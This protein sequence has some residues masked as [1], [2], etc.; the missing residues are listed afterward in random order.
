MGKTAFLFSGQGSQYVGMGMELYNSYDIVRDTLDSIDSILGYNLLDIIFNGPEEVLTKTENTQPAILAVSIAIFK[1]LKNLGVEAQSAVG[2]S[3]GEYTALVASGVLK[4]ED[5]LPLVKKRGKFMQEAVP[6]GIGAMAAIIG[7]GRDEVKSIIETVASLGLAEAVN[8]NCPGQIA[9]AGETRVIQAAVE[10][11]KEKGATR[12]VLL[13]VSAPFHSSMLK[14]AGDKLKIELNNI[15]YF[16]PSI[17][18][19]ANVDCKYYK[20]EKQDVVE[21]LTRQVYNPVLFEDSIS[22]L[23]KDGFDTFIEIGPG[24]ALSGFVKR[25]SKEVSI[26]NVEDMKSMEKLMSSIS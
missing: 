18:V 23:I 9:I 16:Q 4:F 10:L 24:R 3:L 13:K 21:K 7:L 5:A 19:I 25:I 2:L 1:L 6:E 15:S 11:A 22:K 26:F 20:A 8:Y 12:S 17:P 14:G